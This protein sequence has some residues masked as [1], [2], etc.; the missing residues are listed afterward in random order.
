MH[1]GARRWSH[2]PHL[3]PRV[4]RQIRS[5]L[6]APRARRQIRPPLLTLEARRQGRSPPLTPQAR[7]LI[8]PPLLVLR[9]GRWFSLPPLS[10]RTHFLPH[11]MGRVPAWMRGYLSVYPDSPGH[12]TRCQQLPILL[13]PHRHLHHCWFPPCAPT[14]TASAA[15]F[16][17]VLLRL[18][19]PLS[20]GTVGH[21]HGRILRQR[22]QKIHKDE[23]LRLVP[24]SQ[25]QR[26][27]VGSLIKKEARG[28]KTY[29]N[30]VS[31]LRLHLHWGM[32][33]HRIYKIKDSVGVV[34]RRLH[35]LLD[36]LR[37]FRGVE[38]S[39]GERRPIE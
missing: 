10:S 8:H 38:C 22:S 21:C 9:M 36:A 32:P 26:Q 3:A 19:L 16:S 31:W 20:H 4:R 7:R 5:P 6:L 30:N 23:L 2:P 25:Y 17:L 15:S 13:L 39:L 24:L 14:R 37:H 18:M 34:P 27:E 35:R 11:E 12:P 33:R 29:E 1:S 28:K